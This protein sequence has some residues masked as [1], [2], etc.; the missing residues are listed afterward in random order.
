MTKE[1]QVVL[2]LVK[3]GIGYTDK[4]D[5]E[6]L[7]NAEVDWKRVSEITVEQSVGAIAYVGADRIDD[8]RVM[9]PANVLL[10]WTKF[11][12]KTKENYMLHEKLLCSLARYFAKN[13]LSIMVLKGL[14]LSESYPVPSDRQCGDIDIMMMGE[15]GTRA[16]FEKSNELIRVKDVKVECDNPKHSA[17]ELKGVTIENHLMFSDAES[18]GIEK[19]SEDILQDIYKKE[20]ML[21]MDE[22]GDAP[23]IFKPSANLN[24]LFLLRHMAKH[25]GGV[26]TINLRQLCDWGVFLKQYG[27]DIDWKMCAERVKEMKLE[28]LCCIFTNIAQMLVGVELPCVEAYM[29]DVDEISHKVLDD[30]FIGQR[31]LPDRGLA[32][33]IAKSRYFWNQRW[34]YR[35]MHEN[36]WLRSIKAFGKSM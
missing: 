36:F 20:N 33:T 35:Y 24:Y 1:Q 4:C 11:V 23:E 2:E 25:F 13:G 21:L 31:N 15:E 18:S 10:E 34:K 16:A 19:R 6:V 30:L 32:R 5:L 7:S 29:D 12:D 9:V 3:L 28:K 26:D 17:Y 22:H 14:G 8:E 27:G